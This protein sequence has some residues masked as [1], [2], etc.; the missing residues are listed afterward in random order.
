MLPIVCSDKALA[1][2]NGIVAFVA[3]RDFTA[4]P[5]RNILDQLHAVSVPKSPVTQAFPQPSHT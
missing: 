3:P 2:L 1:D 4:T 5:A